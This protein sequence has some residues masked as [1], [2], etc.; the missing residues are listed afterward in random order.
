MADHSSKSPDAATKEAQQFWGFLFR[1]DKCG[2]DLLNRLLE[3]IA[4]YVVRTLRSFGTAQ[5]KLTA[6]TT[7]RPFRANPG[8]RRHHAVAARWLL[9]SRWRRL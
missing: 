1:Q 5:P 3:G 8:L 2:T 9:Q 7:G 4:N 6:R